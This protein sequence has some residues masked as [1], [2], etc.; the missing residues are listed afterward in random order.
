MSLPCLAA[1]PP[2]P[3]S[4]SPSRRTHLP[5]ELRWLLRERQVVAGRL[6]D[7]QAAVDV[8]RQAVAALEATLA[9]ERTRLAELEA[10][11]SKTVSIIRAL[12]TSIR[13]GHPGAEQLP[14]K[15]VKQHTRFGARGSLIAFL[16]EATTD[17]GAQ[18]ITTGQLVDRAAESFGMSVV[19]SKEREAL[20][21]TVRSRMRELRDLH[22]LVVGES[23]AG[24]GKRT[25]NVW[26][27]AA[28]MPL[29]ELRLNAAAQGV[30]TAGGLDEHSA[31]PNPVRGEVAG[32]R[33]VSPGR[34]DA[35]D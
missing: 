28:S 18:G 11:A 2:S 29:E 22:G 25:E 6:V 30:T 27:R 13:L 20:R 14:I 31:H 5:P 12:E 34:R 23:R 16:L 10:T 26:R 19:T 21:F 15:P 33:A 4:P 35:E 24:V 1:V 7:E 32:Q 17:A 9:A 8:Q 3:T